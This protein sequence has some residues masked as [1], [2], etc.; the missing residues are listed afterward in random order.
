MFVVVCSVLTKAALANSSVDIAPVPEWTDELEIREFETDRSGEFRDGVAYLLHDQQ[1]RK[2]PEGYDYAVRIVYRVTDRSGLES[3][4]QVSRVFDPTDESLALNFIRVLRD[5]GVV[6]QGQ[7]TEVTV[8]RQEDGLEA[9]IIDGRLTAVVNLEDIRVGDIIDYSFS[10]SVTSHLWPDHYFEAVT[11]EWAVPLAQQRYKISVPTELKLEAR[12]V[13]TK[14]KPEVELLEDRKSMVVYQLDPDP[15]RLESSV[16][17][18]WVTNGFIEFSTME[19]WSAVAEWAVPVFSVDPAL[20]DSFAR[21]LD[22]IGEAYEN[23]VDRATHVLRLVQEEIRYLGIEVGLG[24]HVPRTPAETVKNGYGDCKDKSVLLV[25]ALRYL[26]IDAVPALASMAYG[27]L[28]PQVPPTIG[29]FDHA[30]VGIDLDGHRYWVDPTLSHQGGS[31]TELA[32]LEYGYVLPIEAQQTQLEEI[33]VEF[34]EMPTYQVVEEFE[35]PESDEVGL[36]LRS[37]N[38]YRGAKADFIRGWIARSGT[39]A[40]ETGYLDYYAESYSGLREDSPLVIADD[41]ESNVVVITASYQLDAEA[42]LSGG[43]NKHLP[44]SLD[45]IKNALPRPDESVRKA[46]LDLPFGVNAEHVIRVSKPGYRLPLA[47]DSSTTVSG[48]TYARGFRH[49]GDV[50]ELKSNLTVVEDIASHHA[51]PAVAKLADSI[52]EDADLN[53]LLQSAVPTLSKQ[54]GLDE[55]LS[56]DI[57]SAIHTAL[58]DFANK[59]HIK[60]LTTINTLL[61]EHT[62]ATAIN[63]YLQLFKGVVLQ[64]I[65]RNAAAISAFSTGFE[66]Y[67]PPEPESYFKYADALLTAGKNVRAAQ[68]IATALD[69]L[70]HAV[71]HLNTEW[72]RDFARYLAKEG[73][74]EIVNELLVSTADAAHATKT[75]KIDE[76]RWVFLEAAE[77]LTRTG[78]APQAY[79][80]LIYIKNP[81]DLA[82]LLASKEMEPVWDGV[83]Q[84]TGDN[85]AYA[86]AHY[87]SFTEEAAHAAPDDFKSQTRYL[88]ALRMAQRYEDAIEFGSRSLKT[89]RESRR[90]G[91]TRIGSSTNLPM[92][93]LTRVTRRRPMRCSRAWCPWGLKRTAISYRWPL[94]APSFAQLGKLFGRVSRGG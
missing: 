90:W 56:P 84:L 39:K 81:R 37:E 6:D 3:A 54:L 2:T 71:N 10:G 16:P 77:H 11:V 30:I 50:F 1:V 52:A 40:L 43:Y 25:A 59:D 63:G 60:A 69:R 13:A 49:D 70:P 18:E 15:V 38:T 21:Q 66:H 29:R 28:L 93:S 83:Y 82:F 24:S 41:R 92:C 65:G 86:V 64:S 57:E 23:P 19:S 44:V 79:Q 7:D 12:P 75:H 17:G 46:P 80:F 31:L 53:I 14:L 58:R 9:G 32:D 35:L 27:E 76:I 94:I 89:G 22:E 85:L 62:D 47:E 4:A 48:V 51:V 8:L 87:V 42:Y 72:L 36:R 67:E 26:G 33:T 78:R 91:L 88:T 74:T 68:T 45:A 5:D 73:E 61:A 34:P 20:P 55:P